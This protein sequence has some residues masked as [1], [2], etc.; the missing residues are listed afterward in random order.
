MHYYIMN[1][2]AGCQLNDLPFKQDDAP[3]LDIVVH[4]DACSFPYL[5]FHHPP[6]GNI[7]TTDRGWQ[8]K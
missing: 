8:Y 4:S 1:I 5:Y 3:N 7:N 2:L 6:H